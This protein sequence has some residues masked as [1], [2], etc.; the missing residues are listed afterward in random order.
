MIIV[1]LLVVF[2][3]SAADAAMN[4]EKT[5]A[6]KMWKKLS[7]QIK[8]PDFALKMAIQGQV[9]LI[10][11]VSEKGFIQIKNVLT[12]EPELAEFVKKEL[13]DLQCEEMIKVAG[14]YF[15]VKFHFRLI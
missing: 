5:C 9:T 12:D 1:I 4:P 10:F 14:E 15:K 6:E 2:S 11:T 7:D 13:S 3:A 8:Y